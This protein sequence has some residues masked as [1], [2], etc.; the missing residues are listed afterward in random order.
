MVDSSIAR[1]GEEQG[2]PRAFRPSLQLPAHAIELLRQSITMT[3]KGMPKKGFPP[4]YSGSTCEANR[5]WG[6]M[7]T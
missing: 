3:D 4:Q 2:G 7:R 5:I 1:A 6:C